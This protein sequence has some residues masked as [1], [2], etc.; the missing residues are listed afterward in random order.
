MK[1]SIGVVILSKTAGT[2]PLRRSE[3]T[4]SRCNTS[5]PCHSGNRMIGTSIA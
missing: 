4:F 5:E 3:T 2:S 1:P